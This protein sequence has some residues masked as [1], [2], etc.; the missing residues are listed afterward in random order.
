MEEQ[1]LIKTLN[2]F[3][4][5]EL[6]EYLMF[7]H[8]SEDIIRE[9]ADRVNWT[10]ISSCQHLSEGFIREFADKVDWEAVSEYQSLS[11]DFIREFTDRVD[12]NEISIYQRLSESF[13]E[14][15]QNNVHWA[16]ISLTQSFSEDFIR[17][18][19]EKLNWDA[20]RGNKYLSGIDIDALHVK[21]LSSGFDFKQMG[22]SA[23]N[24]HMETKN[25]R[26]I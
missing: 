21:C 8:V 16:Y 25:S 11:E 14:E 26:R 1:Q 3:T 5:K 17:K 19:T 20:L 9:F 2:L 4:S 22:A 6:D 12:W 23:V 24:E 7:N 13:I 15:F 10:G 18:F